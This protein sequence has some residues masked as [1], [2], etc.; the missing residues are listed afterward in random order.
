MDEITEA[1]FYSRLETISAQYLAGYTELEDE[2]NRVQEKLSVPQKLNE[3]TVKG[4]GKGYSRG[5]KGYS[6]GQREELSN[7]K[8]NSPT[9]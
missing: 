9:R 1:A 3:Q 8:R 5:G 6:R 7:L 4:R 2:R